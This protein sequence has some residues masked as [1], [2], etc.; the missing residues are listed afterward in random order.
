MVGGRWSLDL[1]HARPSGPYTCL[2]DHS[3][4]GHA[5]LTYLS[6]CVPHC[7]PQHSNTKE[8][9][10]VVDTPVCVN[11][12][13]G[14]IGFVY[15]E[16]P[17][18]ITSVN[19]TPCYDLFNVSPVVGVITSVN[20]TPCYDLFNVSPVVGVITIVIDRPSCWSTIC[21][22]S[23]VLAER[24][25]TQSSEPAFCPNPTHPDTVTCGLKSRD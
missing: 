25:M 13:L 4:S 19:V 14:L 23:H 17:V 10:K 3:L 18:G 22:L 5:R 1:V 20:V 15:T 2:D 16:L 8:P 7:S 11:T 9:S 12:T 21:K 24:W 6:P